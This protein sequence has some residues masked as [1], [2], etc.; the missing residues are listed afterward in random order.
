MYISFVTNNQEHK[1][2]SCRQSMKSS[3]I[4]SFL[5]YYAFLSH[6]IIP[7][8]FWA[9]KVSLFKHATTRLTFTLKLIYD[10][11]DARWKLLSG[12]FFSGHINTKQ[13]I[14]Q[15]SSIQYFERELYFIIHYK[16][17][18]ENFP[19]LVTRMP[20][21]VQGHQKTF[22]LSKSNY[23]LPVGLAISFLTRLAK[24]KSKCLLN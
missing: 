18:Q 17:I 4:L 5:C 9:N 7:N 2:S 20:I 14:Y 21:L 12:C 10:H 24:V 16:G 11:C 1:Y 23:M 8:C 15:V 13:S 6:G 3:C 19:N 22:W